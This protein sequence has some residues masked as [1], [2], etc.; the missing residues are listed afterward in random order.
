MYTHIL[1][2]LNFNSPVSIQPNNRSGRE[3]SH[4]AGATRH[5]RPIRPCCLILSS[6]RHSPGT[7]RCIAPHACDP[8]PALLPAAVPPCRLPQP[9]HH[10]ESGERDTETRFSTWRSGDPRPLG[11]WAVVGGRRG[12][13]VLR[14]RGRPLAA[15]EGARPR[16]AARRRIESCC[17]GTGAPS[18]GRL[19]T[20][21]WTTES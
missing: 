1:V 20:V 9:S 5:W 13:H 15:G 21:G 4:Q 2:D 17:P 7:H 8:S 6:V 10:G 18:P 16:Q 19:T 12:P 11:T 14:A 3:P